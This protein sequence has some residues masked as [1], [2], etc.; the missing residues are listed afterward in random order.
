VIKVVEISKIKKG[1][2]IIEGG[3]AYKVT[4]ITHSKAGKHGHG[5]YRLEATSVIGGKKAS[6]IL[7]SGH[8][9]D[10]PI[11][12]KKNAQVLTVEERVEER[13]KERITK[14]VANVMDTDTYETFDIEVPDELAPNVKEGV[15]V[16]L[17]DV[18]GVRLMKQIVQ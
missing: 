14:R 9:I 3:E 8:K 13:G 12:E 18:M 10:V 2:Y 4:S 11:I 16:L 5:K 6:V 17:W 1:G 7:C 15:K